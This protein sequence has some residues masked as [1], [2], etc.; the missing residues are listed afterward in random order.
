MLYEVFKVKRYS[1]V[2]F[3]TLSESAI[4]ESSLPTCR[5][6]MLCVA[7]S[8]SGVRE[9]CGDVINTLCQLFAL[10]TDD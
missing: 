3:E 4:S 7:C 6:T 9:Q 10:L 2:T 8:G 5:P 1:V